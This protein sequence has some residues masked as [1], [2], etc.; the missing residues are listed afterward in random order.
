MALPLQSFKE[1]GVSCFKGHNVKEL[2]CVKWLQP[3]MVNNEE[4][5]PSIGVDPAIEV[6]HNKCPSKGNFYQSSLRK[7]KRPRV[8]L[9]AE[10][11]RLYVARALA[12]AE[13]LR[14]EVLEYYSEFSAS[15]AGSIEK[16]PDPSKRSFIIDSGASV[17]F[18][19]EGDL[20]AE[21]WAGRRKLK[22]P[23]V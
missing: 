23:H 13:K 9:L 17:N 11:A 15:A 14:G 4:K 2:P 1:P 18:I 6:R 5:Y 3:S 19:A 16:R 7:T 8:P 21:E 22:V 20:T 10:E 12:K